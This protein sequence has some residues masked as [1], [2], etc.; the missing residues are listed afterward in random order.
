M[1]K[2]LKLLTG[3]LVIPAA[4][5]SCKEE[6]P[7]MNTLEVTPS[8][9]LEFAALDNEDKVLIVT[10]DASSWEADAPEWVLTTVEGDR[11]VVNVRDNVSSESRA[12]RITVSA[13]NA[14]PVHV[15]VI[16]NEAEEDVDILSVTPDDPI[17][18]NASGNAGVSLEVS[19]NAGDWAFDVPEWIT[20]SKH[21]GNILFVNAED[22]P[23][24]QQRIGRI[25][26]SAG[27]AEPVV[28]NVMQSGRN[29]SA[30]TAGIA[31]GDGGDGSALVIEKLD[32]MP[33]KLTVSLDKAL[34]E[35]VSFEFVYDKE[36]LSQYNYLNGT[37]YLLYPE[38]LISF[39]EDGRLTISSGQTDAETEI[40]IDP[41]SRSLRNG[42]S[43]LIPVTV[44]TSSKS[45]NLDSDAMRVN[46]V[47]SRKCV[48][49]TKTILYFE[50]NDV[51]PLNALEYRLEDGTMFFDAVV[52]FSANIN[53]DYQNGRPY[54]YNN[55]SVQALLDETDTYLQPLREAG[56]KV[57]LGQLG[58]HDCAGLC[59]LSKTGA[60]YY[61][62][63]LADAVKRYKLDGVSFDDEYSSSPISSE[64][65]TSPSPE[66]GARLLYE[67]K[68]AMKEIVPWD[69]DVQVYQL[70][71]FDTRISSVDGHRPGEFVDI[72]VGD[73]GRAGVPLN[74][75][76]KA[77]CSV[78]SVELNLNRG[79]ISAAYHAEAEGYGWMMY[80]SFDPVK[81]LSG[82]VNAFTVGAQGL[83]G[84]KLLEPTGIY[85][86]KE[87][88][89]K[90]AF[91]PVRYEL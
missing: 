9:P 51:N 69:T 36:Y 17:S 26:V 10:T 37:D 41:D 45:V 64:Y 57:Y 11:L 80:F 61:A 65:L 49:D 5:T 54:L 84:M 13:G 15:S 29:L 32:L 68:Q 31:D 44:R 30:V 60:K 78:M 35:D 85:K 82:G 56:I 77:S 14:E 25:T 42:V 86:K 19:T 76:T 28:I 8:S 71:N 67:T 16:Q 23:S 62:Q 27:E 24:E 47:I 3:V 63:I 2:V 58:N 70:G 59:Q 4:I 52:L 53:W 7:A 22:N 81:K 34:E 87:A 21:D 40:I 39:G 88:G 83:W 38:D 90:G 33:Q 12:G 73:Y 72:V 18:F 20:A 74:G 66:A 48:K 91:D 75:M 55:P 1:N 46:W 79:D 6:E 89:E 43:Y 50:V